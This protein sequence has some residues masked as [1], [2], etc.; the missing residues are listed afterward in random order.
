M[1]AGGEHC[2]LRAVIE[3]LVPYSHAPSSSSVSRQQ[4]SRS[5]GPDDVFGMHRLV[6]IG[7]L[8]SRRRDQLPWPISSATSNAATSSAVS[9][10]STDGLLEAS[11]SPSPRPQ[12]TSFLL[13]ARA[14]GVT[15]RS[16]ARTRSSRPNGRIPPPSRQLLL[17][18]PL[19][20]RT[21]SSRTRKRV[22]ATRTLIVQV[23]TSA[24]VRFVS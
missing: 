19:A 23:S 8:G 2:Q 15:F 14:I 21:R 17:S 1:V 7:G 10:T 20:S 16:Q 9:S 22:C 4:K 18:V 13:R 6:F 11:G 24:R 12:L 3:V 5:M